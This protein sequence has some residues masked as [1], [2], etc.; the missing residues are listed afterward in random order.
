MPM[1]S[2]PSMGPAQS[3]QSPGGLLPSQSSGG[4]MSSQSSGGSMSSQSSGGLLPSRPGGLLPGRPGDTQRGGLVRA[5]DDGIPTSAND[6]HFK[7]DDDKNL[8]TV[9]NHESVQLSDSI[10][11]IFQKLMDSEKCVER[12]ACRV[13]VAEKT[14]T[15]PVWINW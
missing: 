6:P 4:S 13:S 10:L 2:S 7:L 14:G 15:V 8:T 9:R 12:I 3:S 5:M 11:N 1:Q